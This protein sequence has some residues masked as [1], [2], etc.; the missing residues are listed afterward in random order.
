MTFLT[1]PEPDD[2]PGSIWPAALM[3][4]GVSGALVSLVALAAIFGG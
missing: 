1:V 3:Y 2:E 4:F